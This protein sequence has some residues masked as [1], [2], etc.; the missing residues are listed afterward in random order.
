ML[1]LYRIYF[2]CIALPLALLSTIIA[3]LLTI[4]GCSLGGGGWFGYWP[5]HIWAR[6]I[7]VL[8]LVRVK[9]H[10]RENISADTS[11]V[12]VAN[13]QGAFDIFSVYGYLNHNF[14]W[15][16]KQGLRSIPLVGFACEKS[17]QIYVDKSSPSALRHT[18][19]RA[20][21]LLSDGMSI[22]VFPEGARTW[23]GKMRPFKRGAFLLAQE[24]KLPVIPITID[25][26][27]QILPRFKKLPRP[28][29]IVLTIHHPIE[30]SDAGHDMTRLISD[31]QRAIESALPK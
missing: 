7:C 25:G 21:H 26:A 28:G 14:R 4:V 11:Y 9:V 19:D 27:F 2:F 10:G 12:F 22:V 8:T 6:S 18:M 30:A 3:A 24:F 31:S 13:H 20:E 23:D 16:M 1:F 17:H 29:K 5:A 15:M